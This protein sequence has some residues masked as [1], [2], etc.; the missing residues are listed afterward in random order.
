MCLWA[1]PLRLRAQPGNMAQP[2]LAS[3]PMAK[4][5]E[6]YYVW[7]VR[8]AQIGWSDIPPYSLFTKHTCAVPGQHDLYR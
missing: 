2:A 6:D 8:S 1:G 7:V 3:R 4:E 5:G